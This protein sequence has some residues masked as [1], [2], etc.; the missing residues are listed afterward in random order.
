[1]IN[2]NDSPPKFAQDTYETV[3][4]LPTYLGVE[5]LRVEAFDPD[6]T[7]DPDKSMTSQLIYSLV[8][9]EF[10]S[11]ERSTGIVTVV[12]PNLNK[13]RYRFNVKVSYWPCR[14][15][16]P[17]HR[18]EKLRHREY[19]WS[20]QAYISEISLGRS[21]NGVSCSCKPTAHINSLS[22]CGM[23]HLVV[24]RVV[25]LLSCHAVALVILIAD[26]KQDV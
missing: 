1:M 16:E 2:I 13:E 21:E 25:S 22:L 5:V 15:K 24:N 26:R 23:L 18:T 6:L 17:H 9:T 11:I 10:F 20:K 4:L 8:D 19:N 7:S 3:L 14:F 12:N